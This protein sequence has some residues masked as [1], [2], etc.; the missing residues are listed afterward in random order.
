MHHKVKV[1]LRQLDSPGHNSFQ[2]KHWEGIGGFH[3]DV[4]TIC[5]AK[6]SMGKVQWEATYFDC[7]MNIVLG[8]PRAHGSCNPEISVF[9]S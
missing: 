6:I 2:S 8:E 4:E 5:G 9:N 1:H 3:V 7:S